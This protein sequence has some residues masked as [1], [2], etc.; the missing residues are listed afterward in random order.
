MARS[1]AARRRE[2]DHPHGDT[3]F[4]AASANDQAITAWD[5]R[6]AGIADAI[7]PDDPNHDRFAATLAFALAD[8]AAPAS[9]VAPYEHIPLRSRPYRH[10]H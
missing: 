10:P 4:A 5:L 9:A 1:P 2:R 3:S 6:D 8:Q 7:I